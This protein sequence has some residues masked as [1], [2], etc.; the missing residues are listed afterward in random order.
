MAQWMLA[1]LEDT[2]CAQQAS[3]ITCAPV[4]LIRDSFPFGFPSPEL[5]SDKNIQR[6]DCEFARPFLLHAANVQHNYNKR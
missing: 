5:R 2:D 1:E 4:G 3:L 6:N